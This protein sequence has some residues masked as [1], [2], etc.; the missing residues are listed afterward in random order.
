MVKSCMVAPGTK[1]PRKKT[2]LFT[3]QS[4]STG[5]PWRA[6]SSTVV[7]DLHACDGHDNGRSDPVTCIHRALPPK[8]SLA[9][10]AKF[11]LPKT[12]KFA[13]NQQNF[14]KSPIFLKRMKRVKKSQILKKSQFCRKIKLFPQILKFSVNLKFC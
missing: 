14:S 11:T 1:T 4:G 13:K 10:A 9:I 6:R 5:R 7:G 3:Q 8:G 2:N 12:Q